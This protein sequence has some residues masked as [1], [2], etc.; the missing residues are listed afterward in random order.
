MKSLLLLWKEAAE[1][2]GGWCRVSTDRDFKTVTARTNAEG[3][4]FLT[5]T[6]AD[7]AKDFERS[8][9]TGRV[10]HAQFLGFQRKGELPLFLGGF[11]D[12]V[13]ARGTGILLP[14]P[15]WEAI[16][17]IRQ[18][19]R[20]Y[21]KI[22]LPCSEGRTRNAFR[23]YMECEN[24]L[25]VSESEWTETGMSQFSR[26]GRL[27]FARVLSDINN[28][29]ANI[30]LVP[31][32]GPGSTA[33]KLS[34][35]AKFNQRSW[36]ER[37]EEVFPAMDYLLPSPRFYANLDR[38]EFIEPGAETPVKVI[39][40]PKT[41]KTPRI[42]AVEPTCMQYAQQAIAGP[43]VELLERD[44]VSKWFLGFRDNKPNQVFA[45]KGSVDGSLAT[46]DMS[47]ASDRV[48]NQLVVEL[49]RNHGHLSEAVAACRS[50][51]A[52]VP[53]YGVIPL[54]KFASMGSALC[55]PFEAMVFLTLIFCGIEN[56]QNSVLSAK[57]LKSFRGKVRVYGDDIIIPVEY[58]QDVTACLEA[59]GF[60]V[61]VNKSFWTGNFRESCGKDYYL[62]HD[63]SVV[64]CRRMIPTSRQH[65]DRIIS[66]VALRNNLYKRGLHKTAAYLDTEIGKVLKHYPLVGP[67]SSILG[68]VEEPGVYDVDGF[69]S[70]LHYP[71]V[72]GY[73]KDIRKR[74]SKLDGPGALLKFF[75]K[76]GSL[77]TTDEEHLVYAG[78]PLSVGI[79]IARARPY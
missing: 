30:S 58:T 64:K 57:D 20:L 74:P 66:T 39:T 67:D 36:P 21:S 51:R 43:L 73:V 54:A 12:Q 32:H 18:L 53:G 69:D 28:D 77:P 14:N 6:L 55:F 65:A 7:Y 17:C 76:Q 42:I 40:V 2:L 16:Y 46:L 37:L 62:G 38:V 9:A 27:L 25:K 45:R 13:F 33:D 50:T 60:K 49:L 31:R 1:E 61:N 59:F 63:V 68:R 8:L 47:E 5:I 23:T 29:V 44:S 11:L 4:S 26:L 41:L 35:N 78:R 22:E 79:K 52:D 19:C 75:L 70:R 48:S 72:K 34:G 10:D 24:G 15:N 71:L 56:A 3:G